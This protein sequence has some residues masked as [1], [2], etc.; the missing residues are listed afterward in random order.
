MNKLHSE[1]YQHCNDAI[2]TIGDF[3]DFEN[4]EV[5]DLVLPKLIF[6]QIDCLFRDIEDESFEDIF[7]YGQAIIPQVEQFAERHGV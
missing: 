4:V 7:A 3:L 6:R 1:L 2:P 5:E